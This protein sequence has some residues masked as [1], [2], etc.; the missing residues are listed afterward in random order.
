MTYNFRI[1][2]A[3]TLIAVLAFATIA[4]AAGPELPPQTQKMSDTQFETWA[5]QSNAQA[6]ARAAQRAEPGTR[7][8]TETTGTTTVTEGGNTY[9]GW[10]CNSL[11]VEPT[12][13]TTRSGTSRRV[14]ELNRYGGGPVWV[15]NPYCTSNR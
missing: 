14:Y 15:V 2:A 9:F 11:F 5:K 3:A 7:V 6:Y 8:L 1:I 12:V 10:G 4:S 13:R